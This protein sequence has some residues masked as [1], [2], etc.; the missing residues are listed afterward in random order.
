[1]VIDA[2]YK[3]TEERIAS[4]LKARINNDSAI[5]NK[6]NTIAPFVLTTYTSFEVYL[7]PMS[8]STVMSGENT[9]INTS[10]F[11]KMLASA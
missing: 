2:K 10:N 3:E 8:T 1:M 9:R 7:P 5:I 4:V 6:L 11:R